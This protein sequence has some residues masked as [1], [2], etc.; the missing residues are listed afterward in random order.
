[1]SACTGWTST[2]RGGCSP[3]RSPRCSASFA[4]R[5]TLVCAQAG[6]INTGSFD[7]LDAIADLTA[8]HGAWLHVDGAF[9]LWAAASPQHRGLVARPRAGRLLGDRRPQV[10]ERPVRQRARLL[11]PSGGASRG[12][13]RP[14][15][16]PRADRRERARP[17]RVGARVLAPGARLHRL[18]RAAPSRQERRRRARRRAAAAMPA[19]SPSCWRRRGA[20]RSS[21]TS[22]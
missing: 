22:C 5:P 15:R 9:G 3:Q 2:A 19:A 6:N 7:P 20:S 4:G 8:A 16:L 14:R 13:H 10:A 21:T 18:G 17:V 1:M 12:A 11:R